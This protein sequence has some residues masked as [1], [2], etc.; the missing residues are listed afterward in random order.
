MPPFSLLIKPV[1]DECNLACRYCYYHGCEGGGEGKPSRPLR[2]SVEVLT[3]VMRAYMQTDQAVYSMIWHGGEPTLL[4]AG[5][6][7]KTIGLQKQFARR[8]SRISNS[9]QT[10]GVKI[11][12]SLARL[13]ARYR[14][15]CGV[16]LDGP[17]D[18]HDRYRRTKQGGKTHHRVMETCRK[19][20][21]AGIP[22]N[23]LVLVS[24]ANVHAPRQLYDYLTRCGFNYIQFIPCV[25]TDAR[26]RRLDFSISAGQWGDFLLSIFNRWVERDT[27]HVSIRLF[28]SILAK[29]VHG[30]A[31]DCYNSDACNRYLVVESNGDVYPCDFYVRPEHRLGN[32]LEQPFGEILE[33]G[34]YRMFSSAKRNYSANCTRCA[35]LDLCMGDCPKY[36][37]GENASGERRS[38]LLCSGWKHFFE[39]SIDRFRYLAAS[40]QKR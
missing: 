25:E 18:L 3:A 31:I 2:M 22:V 39:A 20:A 7:E 4:P 30:T 32:L 15:L 8:G 28:E 13:M 23:I 29:L 1:S 9:I 26:G 40:I 33:D 17:P 5:F 14:F 37:A 21:R 36:R 10:N 11:S 24:Q 16:S 35:F 38:S 19:L 12:E 6:Y 34:R 27:G